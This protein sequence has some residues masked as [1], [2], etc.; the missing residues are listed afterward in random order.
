MQRV[1]A[2]LSLM[3][4]A[5][6]LGEVAQ[7]AAEAR[8]AARQTSAYLPVLV[9]SRPTPTPTRT[10]TATRTAKRTPT[11]TSTLRPTLTVASTATQTGT[12]TV[13][14]TPTATATETATRT[15]TRTP[16][17]TSTPT[18]T[19]TNT[20]TATPTELP[21]P[22][23][24]NG[25]FENGLAPWFGTNIYRGDT[26]ARSGEWFALLSTDHGGSINQYITIPSDKPYLTYW[27]RT[28]SISLTC[29]ATARVYVQ[30]VEVAQHTA[31]CAS[32][33]LPEW[34]QVTVDL[35]AFIGRLVTLTFDVREEV[36]TDPNDPGISEWYMDDVALVAQP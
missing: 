26:G 22:P 16:T 33:N 2:A 19:L 12:A 1:L 18:P 32:Q 34:Q 28:H 15:V 13:T 20:P 3:A 23:I 17:R 31:L 25:G 21:P 9:D 11:R 36:E 30:G 7:S 4:L 27:Y 6:F 35:Q 5:L 10:G 14:N 24:Q 29:N 8:Q